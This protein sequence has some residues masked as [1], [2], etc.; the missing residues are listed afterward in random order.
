[1]PDP[2]VC[3]VAC[4]TACWQSAVVPSKHSD[5]MVADWTVAPSAVDVVGPDADSAS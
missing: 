2:A 5:G 4:E 3:D 1:M